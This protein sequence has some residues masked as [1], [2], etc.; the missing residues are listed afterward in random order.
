[1]IEEKADYEGLAM[2]FK[3]LGKITATAIRWSPTLFP[4]VVFWFCFMTFS[5]LF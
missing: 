3:E 1:M 4:E 5:I 2:L